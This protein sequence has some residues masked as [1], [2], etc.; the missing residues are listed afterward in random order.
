MGGTFIVA[1]DGSPGSERALRAA[2]ELA[3]LSNVGLTLA[4]VIEWSPFSFHTPEELAE[5][6]KRREEELDRAQSAILAPAE[7]IVK[8]EGLSCDLVVKHGNPAEALV[9]IADAAKATHIFVGRKGRSSVGALLF[10]SVAAS[11]IQI[12][13]IPVTFVP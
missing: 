3:K 12:S 9:G 1:V 11:L 10:G 2:I 4:H 6:H 5:R 13:T 7:A 8:A